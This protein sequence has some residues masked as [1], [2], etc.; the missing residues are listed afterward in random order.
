MGARGPGEWKTW[1]SRVEESG[2]HALVMVQNRLEL[3]ELT[4]EQ[5]RTSGSRTSTDSSANLWDTPGKK[6]YKGA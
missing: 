1:R 5:A 3:P 2:V 4:T 6:K